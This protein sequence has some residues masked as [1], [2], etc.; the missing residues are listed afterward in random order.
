MKNTGPIHLLHLIM[1]RR[2]ESAVWKGKPKLW[3]TAALQDLS[4]IYAC[5]LGF[6]YVTLVSVS[7]LSLGLEAERVMPAVLSEPR[8]VSLA[9]SEGPEEPRVTE[10][11]A[12]RRD[13]LHN[14]GA[15]F[16]A[17]RTGSNYWHIQIPLFSSVPS[18]LCRQCLMEQS[19]L[20]YSVNPTVKELKHNWII[21]N[22]KHQT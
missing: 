14:P 1:N 5:V 12:F 22:S 17:A 2:G 3:L 9:A 11:P 13:V 19:V 8:R 21:K 18:E 10:L 4:W 16:P 7:E 20:F 15:S 6:K